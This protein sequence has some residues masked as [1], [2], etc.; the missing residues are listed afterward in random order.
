MTLPDTR[1]E[2]STEIFVRPTRL[3]YPD[4]VPGGQLDLDKPP[5]VPKPKPVPMMQIIFPI[6]IVV[7][8]VGMMA[9]MF[10]LNRGAFNPLFLMFPMFAFISLGGMMFQNLGGRANM[11]ELNEERKSYLSYLDTQREK[12]HQNAL[13]QI[14]ARKWDHPEPGE[15]I[16][17]VAT[18]RMWE[19]R[20]GNRDFA[21]VRIG[22]GEEPLATPLKPEIDVQEEQLEP[23]CALFLKEFI[24]A[25]KSIGA[26]P[27][28]IS[29][30]EYNLIT[31]SGQEV[32]LSWVCALLGQLIVFHGPDD[33]A[34]AIIAPDIEDDD[35]SWAKWLPH[36]QHPASSDASGSA[37]LL[38]TSIDQAEKDLSSLFDKAGEQT[39]SAKSEKRHIVVALDCRRGIAAKHEVDRLARMEG[40]LGVTV[41]AIDAPEGSCTDDTSLL[42]LAIIDGSLY[43]ADKRSPVKDARQPSDKIA[44][45]DTMSSSEMRDLAQQVAR[46]RPVSELDAIEIKTAGA[47]PSDSP[48]RV[49]GDPSKIEPA[50]TQSPRSIRDMLRVPV[51]TTPSGELVYL[52]LKEAAQQG[53]GPH[54][55]LIG[56]TGSGK[57]ELLRTLVLMLALMH[58]PQHL[59]MLLVDYKGGATFL[60]FDA[61]SACIDRGDQS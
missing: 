40:Y 57:S 36:T 15:L 30:R 13:L 58:S 31:V 52:D 11:A 47:F 51:G 35:W 42:K 14:R 34:V 27:L 43:L 12:V 46:Y 17:F 4:K 48:L 60:G 3:R 61:A 38:Y 26:S 45:I 28:S 10:T 41:I 53:M 1:V 2:T 16:F 6:I 54:G 37:R 49:I 44:A 20:S 29:L 59:N 55:L 39:A 25:Y 19:R 5:L 8:M 50:Q 22:L 32:A 33:V 24:D 9:A 23:T 7:M 18:A 56:R 21:T